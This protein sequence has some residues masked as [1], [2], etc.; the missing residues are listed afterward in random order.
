MIPAIV[1]LPELGEPQHVIVLNHGLGAGTAHRRTFEKL[2]Y[3]KRGRVA[4]FGF[5]REH[6]I[7]GGL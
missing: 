5:T 2:L 4:G 1:A 7:G 6:C 3:P